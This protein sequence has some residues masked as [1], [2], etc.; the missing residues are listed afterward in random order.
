MLIYAKR[1]S[2]CLGWPSPS[3]VTVSGLSQLSQSMALLGPRQLCPACVPDSGWHSEQT[4]FSMDLKWLSHWTKRVIFRSQTI[5]SSVKAP[6]VN[7]KKSQAWFLGTHLWLSNSQLSEITYEQTIPSGSLSVPCSIIWFKQ[8]SNLMNSDQKM[9]EQVNRLH[10][11]CWVQM[12]NDSVKWPRY[13]HFPPFFLCF[14][15]FS[16][17]RD[18]TGGKNEGFFSVLREVDLKVEPSFGVK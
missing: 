1:P 9:E 2:C 7:P 11:R 8:T 12:P 18:Q 6:Q 13:C 4:P 16:S 17:Y 15:L 5:S 14:A 10:H 3:T